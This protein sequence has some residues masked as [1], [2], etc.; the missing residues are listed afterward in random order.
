ME[1]DGL[2][3]LPTFKPDKKVHWTQADQRLLFI[4]QKVI[5]IVASLYSQTS[6]GAAQFDMQSQI[7]TRLAIPWCGSPTLAS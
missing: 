6:A 2:G 3:S 4:R 7:S 5:R 1:W